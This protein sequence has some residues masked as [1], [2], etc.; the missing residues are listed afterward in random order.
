MMAFPSTPPRP[1]ISAQPW[2]CWKICAPSWSANGSF[3]N[4]L[5]PTANRSRNRGVNM[6]RKA[7]KSGHAD[8][9]SPGQQCALEALLEH[10]TIQAAARRS[11]V[12]ERQ[13]RR[14]LTEDAFAKAYL[15]R[16]QQKVGLAL[17]L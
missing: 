12:S 2:R 4:L 10:V 16:R 1:C 11:G 14:Y 9:L 17:H 5:G 8:G 13:I 3:H 15:A 7:D 6:A